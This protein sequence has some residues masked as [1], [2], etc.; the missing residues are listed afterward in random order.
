MYDAFSHFLWSTAEFCFWSV[1]V[2]LKWS[3]MTFFFLCFLSSCLSSRHQTGQVKK[4]D[5]SDTVKM[6]QPDSLFYILFPHLSLKEHST[7]LHLVQVITSS[8]KVT[9]KTIF[10]HDCL[11]SGHYKWRLR[12]EWSDFFVSVILDEVLM[13]ALSHWVGQLRLLCVMRLMCA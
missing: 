6:E 7:V 11:I 13:C 2:I 3:N 1:S 8:I 4:L 12:F 10:T 5:F 9:N